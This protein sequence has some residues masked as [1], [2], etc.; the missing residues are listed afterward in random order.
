MGMCMCACVS[1][2]TSLMLLSLYSG[3]VIRVPIVTVMV[4]IVVLV[5]DGIVFF[6]VRCVHTTVSSV[7][8]H[9]F[10]SDVCVCGRVG[11]CA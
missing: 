9:A 8:A 5:S 10:A 11:M 6:C 2:S 3:A 7:S 1:V 4:L